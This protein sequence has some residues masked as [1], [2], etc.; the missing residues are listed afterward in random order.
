M[1]QSILVVDP[2]SVKCGV[3]VLQYDGEILFREIRL[4]KDMK[5]TIEKLLQKFSVQTI[6]VGDSTGKSFIIEVCKAL[7]VEYQV[8]D[9]KYSS[10]EARRLF[11]QMN[12][13]RGWRRVFPISLLHPGVP[14]DDLSAVVIGKRF[15][16]HQKEGESYGSERKSD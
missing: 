5:E 13:P 11:F 12:P 4:T 3:A 10:E 9:E 6:V 8:I 7:P 15:L 2:G 1:G 16:A 14:Y